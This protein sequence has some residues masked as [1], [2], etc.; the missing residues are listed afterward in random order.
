MGVNHFLIFCCVSLFCFV[1]Y[2]TAQLQ[3]E[4]EATL[5]CPTKNLILKEMKSE[6]P[7]F[8]DL[9]SLNA[10]CNDFQK[11]MYSDEE[12]M[13]V[14]FGNGPSLNAR[15]GGDLDVITKLSFCVTDNR[16]SSI[17]IH[18]SPLFEKPGK[19]KVLFN[20]TS[21]G[22]K[23]SKVSCGGFSGLHGVQFM[24]AEEGKATRAVFTCI[25]FPRPN[26]HYVIDL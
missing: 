4:N 2:A 1:I 20:A 23:H 24:E 14:Y 11:Q 25:S 26:S 10:T 6:S 7:F 12:S 18:C 22:H 16:V 8:A 15:C 9:S 19:F 17:A 13:Y 3:C 21:D 5:S